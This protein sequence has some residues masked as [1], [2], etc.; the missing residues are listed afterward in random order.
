[1]LVLGA[2]PSTTALVCGDHAVELETPVE[3][4]PRRAT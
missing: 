4:A 3:P 2:G 1:M